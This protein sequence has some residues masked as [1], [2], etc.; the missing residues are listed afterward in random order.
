MS[1]LS[2]N[3]AVDLAESYVTKVAKPFEKV[4]DVLRAAIDADVARQAAE[5]ALAVLREDKHRLKVEVDTIQAEMVALREQANAETLA[6]GTEL[7]ALREQVAAV[8]NEAQQQ[9]NEARA[10]AGIVVAEAESEAA[11]KKAGL[12]AEVA[13]LETRKGALEDAIKA[14]KAGVASLDAL[15]GR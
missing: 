9:M 6:I 15:G 2:V 1:E 4:R 10:A 11:A 14:L 3:E 5:S 7:Q 13:G 12:L 8:R